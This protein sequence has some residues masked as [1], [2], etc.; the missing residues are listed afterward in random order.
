MFKNVFK[1]ISTAAGNM[2]ETITFWTA[3]ETKPLKPEVS[4]RQL[5]TN[6]FSSR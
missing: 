3:F 4:L 1:F 6:N 5:S 2:E